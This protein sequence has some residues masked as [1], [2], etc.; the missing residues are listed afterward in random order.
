[1]TKEMVLT[2]KSSK[3]VN[4]FGQNDGKKKKNK[5][6]REKKRSQT[7]ENIN[8]PPPSEMYLGRV[9]AQKPPETSLS[10]IT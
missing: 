2:S 1:M 8:Y 4:E 7:K 10:Q 9:D 3:R 6:P 5:Q